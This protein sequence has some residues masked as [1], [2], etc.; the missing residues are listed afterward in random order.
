MPEKKRKKK[1]R[2]EKKPFLPNNRTLF[3]GLMPKSEYL[4]RIR[5][6]E[7]DIPFLILVI[8]LLV[9]GVIIIYSP[10]YA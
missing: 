2:P 7:I 4:S 8:I 9:F 10:S 1:A 5:I 3:K 6:G